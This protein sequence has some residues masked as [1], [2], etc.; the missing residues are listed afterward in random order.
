MR[1]DTVPGN[2]GRDTWRWEDVWEGRREEE[3]DE[4]VE[5]ERSKVLGGTEEEEGKSARVQENRVYFKADWKD[6]GKKKK[7][8]VLGR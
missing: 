5:K 2:N 8:D 6:G 7:L 3:E 4:K 1:T